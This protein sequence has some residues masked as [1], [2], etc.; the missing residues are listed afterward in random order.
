MIID[1]HNHPDWHGHNLDRTLANM[2]RYHIDLAWLL[3][4]E[5]PDDEWDPVFTPVVPPVVGPGP[6]P[7]ARC[8]AYKERA[9]DRFVLGYAPDPRR[10]GAIGRLQA[11]VEIY[12][13]QVCG[14]IKLRMMYD[15]P[16]A[17]RLFRFCGERGLPVTVHL[18]YEFAT[19]HEFPRPNYWYG[20][21][22][23]AFERAVRAC[24]QTIF[25]GHAPGFWAHLSGDD[26]FDRVPYPSGPIV[27][28]GKVVEML[29]RYPNLYCDISAGSGHNAL[30]RD[31]AFAREFLIEFQDRVLYG[32]DYFDNQHQELLDSLELP[33]E[34]AAK[35]YASNALRLAPLRPASATS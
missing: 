31:L 7:F 6:I 34:V 32:R 1:A 5:C 21:G 33:T 25:I 35:I 9:P 10:P 3:S 28:G 4:W 23:E 18:D 20:G 16:D 15:N 27:P 30:K 17:L 8:L 14:E 13:V 2:D 22:I 24:P 29:R 26:Q 12:G 11:A 19:G